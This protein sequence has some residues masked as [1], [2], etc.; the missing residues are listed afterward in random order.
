MRLDDR[1]NPTGRS[2][3]IPGASSRPASA[4]LPQVIATIRCQQSRSNRGRFKCSTPEVTTVPWSVN[5]SARPINTSTLV[6]E[7]ADCLPTGTLFSSGQFDQ[8]Q[9]H[10]RVYLDGPQKRPR[11]RRD[12]R[13]GHPRRELGPHCCI[14]GNRG[15]RSGSKRSP[16]WRVTISSGR[17]A[18]GGLIRAFQ[19]SNISIYIDIYLS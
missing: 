10:V 15:N 14:L 7:A 17:R 13:P 2:H 12:M 6:N 8:R 18:A 5:A 4:D 19:H 11:N 9:V 1:G 3:L 16:K